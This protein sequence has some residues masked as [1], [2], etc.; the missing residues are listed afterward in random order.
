[1][2]IVARAEYLKIVRRVAAAGPLRDTVIDLQSVGAAT[3]ASCFWVSELAAGVSLYDGIA[4][5]ASQGFVV[6]MHNRCGGD[7]FLCK[8]LIS[9]SFQSV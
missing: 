2:A 7:F 1:M 4:S 3:L 6:T 9:E 8:I 5:F